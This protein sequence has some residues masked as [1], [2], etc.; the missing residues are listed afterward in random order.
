MFA[1]RAVEQVD[2]EASTGDVKPEPLADMQVHYLSLDE[3]IACGPRD[4]PQSKWLTAG[5]ESVKEL[6]ETHDRARERDC[7]HPARREFPA[8]TLLAAPTNSEASFN[9]SNFL[10]IRAD[11][12]GHETQMQVEGISPGH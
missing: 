1:A 8:V 9:V 12:G 10:R 5:E 3:V 6:V 7:D 11:N 4:G 2:A